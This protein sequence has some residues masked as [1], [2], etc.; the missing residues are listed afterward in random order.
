MGMQETQP[1]VAIVLCTYNGAEFIEQQLE[2]IVAQDWPVILY[3]FDDGSQDA[4]LAL[5]NSFSKALKLHIVTNKTNLGYVANFE[6]GI[7]HV[8]D[9]KHNYLA[10]CDQDDIWES[11]RI[12][13]GMNALLTKEQVVGE[14]SAVLVH[15]DLRM[16]DAQNNKLHCSFF[17]YRRYG[18]TKRKSLPLILGQNG[19]M[20]NTVLMN[21]SMA[22]M[23]LPFPT[24]LHVHDYWLALLSELYGYRLLLDKP[25]VNYR[26][27]NS[28]ASNS[29]EAI[30]LGLPSE[31]KS[32]IWLNWSDRDLELPFKEDS[33]LH[34]ILSITENEHQFPAMD[35]KQQRILRVF[36]DYLEFKQSRFKILINMF[37]YGFFRTGI[38]HRARVI[39]RTFMT[40]RYNQIR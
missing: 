19:V 9:R 11:D 2:S 36:Q 8:L 21:R 23:A 28:N 6:A 7:K 35:K 13:Q 15:C 16:I 40:K 24:N 27:H 30:P 34:S 31:R 3:V 39:F 4:T 5:V 26:I 29:S 37:R 20:G 32:R 1:E 18:L 22:S 25:L 10:L 38:K 17:N 33:R 12:S 14:T